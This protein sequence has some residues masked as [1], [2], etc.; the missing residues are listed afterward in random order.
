M[1][2]FVTGGTGFIGKFVVRK[3]NNGKHTILI[4]TRNK[5]NSSTDNISFIKGDMADLP[6]WKDQ[7]KR[8]EPDAAIHLAWEGIPDYGAENSIKNLKLSLDL[9][10]L[11]IAIKCQTILTTGSLW[12]YGDQSGKLSEDMPIKPFNA[13]TAAKNSLNWLG[14]EL[15]KEEKINFIWTRL[16]YVY[17]PGL[18]RESLIPYLIKCAKENRKPEIRNLNARNDFIFV[19]DVADAICELILKCH[20][21]DVFNIGSGRLTSVQ[22]IAEKIYETFKMKKQFNRGKQ[23]QLDFLD[24]SFADISKIRRET[25]WKPWID[26]DQG[27]LKTIEAMA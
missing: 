11:L 20:K 27:L 13:F 14:S 10:E 9:L 15:A 17:G 12:E 5:Q 25:D 4:L 23:K 16:F 24:S 19:E 8:F 18:K 2:I 1:K 21:S 26:I 22:Y 3:L 7:L 6:K